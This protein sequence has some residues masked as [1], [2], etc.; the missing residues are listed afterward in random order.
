[1]SDS[2]EKETT[3]TEAD[4]LRAKRATVVLSEC[5]KAAMGGKQAPLKLRE[6]MQALTRALRALEPIVRGEDRSH[7]GK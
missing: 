1:M 2:I 3:F 6:D 5:F 4:L 7:E